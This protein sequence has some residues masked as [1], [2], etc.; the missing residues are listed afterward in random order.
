MKKTVTVYVVLLLILLIFSV[1]PFA[2]CGGKEAEKEKETA[3]EE[4]AV[5]DEAPAEEEG[6]SAGTVPGGGED[7]E[8]GP[9]ADFLYKRQKIGNKTPLE[10]LQLVDVRWSSHG[11]YFRV[12]AELKRLDGTD[13]TNVP[14]CF[15]A[16]SDDP[17]IEYGTEI[18]LYIRGIRPEDIHLSTLRVGE[19]LLTGDPECYQVMMSTYGSLDGV[20]PV[21]LFVSTRTKRPFRLTYATA[22]LRIILDIWK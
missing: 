7:A 15:A 3:A 16:Y 19:G 22:P 2:G 12:V 4:E 5:V 17:T 13:A 1:T 10:Y 6:E 14:W 8:T 21:N 18:C 20:D 11:D 9:P